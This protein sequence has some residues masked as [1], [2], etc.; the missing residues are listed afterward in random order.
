M[1]SDAVI[2]ADAPAVRARLPIAVMFAVT[3]VV[4]LASSRAGAQ[5]RYT[6]RD[7]ALLPSWCRHTQLIRDAVPG[8]NLAEYQRLMTVTKGMFQHMHHYCFGLIAQND[9]ILRARD[10]QRRTSLLTTSINEFDY[11][12]R[13]TTPDFIMLPEILTKRADSL[14][15]LGR[16]PEAEADLQRAVGAKPNYWPAWLALADYY[17]ERVGD[18]AKAA[19]TL[20]Q[21][22]AAAPEAAA[23]KDRLAELKGGKRR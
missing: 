10:P 11:V 19:Y 3:I 23:L 15:R 22:I 13:N 5:V 4:V 6:E 17:H 8:G 21:G 9:A 18:T 16:G 14:I 20:E 1:G 2:T 7:L 12:L